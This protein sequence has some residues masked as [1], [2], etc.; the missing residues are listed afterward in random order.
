MG[1]QIIDPDPDWAKIMDPDPNWAKIL[2]PYPNSI[3][4]DPQYCLLV[5]LELKILLCN[6]R[7]KIIS[8]SRKVRGMTLACPEGCGYVTPLSQVSFS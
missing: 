8:R 3:Y 2:D 1:Q 7:K 4:L 6:V 5:D